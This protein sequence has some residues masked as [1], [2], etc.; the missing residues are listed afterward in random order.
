MRV[1]FLSS[2]IYP[3]LTGRAWHDLPIIGGSEIQ[4]LAIA[5]ELRGRGIDVSFVT[6]DFGQGPETEAGGFRVHAY[7]FGRNKLLQ[8]RTLWKA[9]DRAESDLDY[10]RGVPRF[11][12]LW[13]YHANRIRRPFVIGMSTNRAVF[14]RPWNGFSI[15]EDRAYRWALSRAGTVVAQTRFQRER[16][17]DTYGVESV[18]LI[19]NASRPSTATRRPHAERTSAAWIASLHPYKGITRLFDLAALRPGFTFEVIGGAERRSEGYYEEMKSRAA[20][21][22]NVRWMGVVENDAIDSILARSLALVHTTVPLP[23]IPNLEGFPNVYLEAWR[24][25]VPVLT[26]DNDPD[27]VIA[28]RGLGMRVGDIGEVAR[29]L[30]RLRENEAEWNALSE[31]A[32]RHFEQEHSIARA[33]DLYADL[34]RRLC[35]GPGTRGR[36]RR[37]NR[38]T[39]R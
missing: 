13:A 6:E 25:G 3:L 29:S 8:G 2:N 11:L 4:Q 27:G 24:N 37:G 1:S 34:F 28:S 23:G 35:A 31:S 10:I 21:L 15:L 22:P 20:G 39:G 5:S 38:R 30:D 26:L 19:P 17:R 33:G 7:R 16:L 36:T 32:L 14:P 12:G 9:L 18:E